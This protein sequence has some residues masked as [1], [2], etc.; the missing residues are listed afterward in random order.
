MVSNCGLYAYGLVDRSPEPLDIVGI[1]QHSKVF[2]L[3]GN[4]SYVM[5]SEINVAT[6]QHQVKQQLSALTDTAEGFQQAS[7]PLLQAHEDVVDTLMHC[8]TVVPFQFGT[9]L[10]DTA[11]VFKMLQEN[12]EQFKNLLVKFAARA[13]WGLKVYV[14]QQEF[15]KYSMHFEPEL[16]KLAAQ[17]EEL[18]KGIAY[19]LGRKMEEELKEKTLARLAE[20]CEAIF[21]QLGTTA[22]EAKLNRPQKLTGKK[23]EMILNTAYLV[24][25]ARSATFCQQEAHLMEHYSS[26]GLELELSGPWPPYSFIA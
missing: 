21:L 16:Q 6:F 1:D 5:V 23:K 4:A 18:S 26:M 2:P 24:E 3:A 11:A 22:H 13:E 17:R 19:L 12:E 14:D 9:I 8:S 15:S 7:A 25:N 10:K 20:V